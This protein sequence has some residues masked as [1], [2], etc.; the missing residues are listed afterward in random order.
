MSGIKVETW[1]GLKRVHLNVDASNGVIFNMPDG[2]WVEISYRKTDGTLSLTCSDTMVLS[3][4][5]A[6]TCR[7]RSER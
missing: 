4:V 7:I 1:E 3:L 2:T 6:N 5:A